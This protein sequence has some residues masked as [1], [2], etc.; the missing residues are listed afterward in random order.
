MFAAEPAMGEEIE[1]LTV[2]FVLNTWGSR[3][4]K[5]CEAVGAEFNPLEEKDA[6]GNVVEF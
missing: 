5:Q 4:S 6:E 2:R 1:K 3:G